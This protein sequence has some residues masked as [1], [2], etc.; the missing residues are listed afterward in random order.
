M[1]IHAV[2]SGK[3]NDLYI[4]G[5]NSRVD[6]YSVTEGLIKIKFNQGG[7]PSLDWFL[8]AAGQIAGG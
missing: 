8:A 1:S 7:S 6:I 5:E 2:Y 4:G 3:N